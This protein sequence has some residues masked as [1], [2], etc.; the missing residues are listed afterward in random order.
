MTL[1]ILLNRIR[2]D[3]N[4]AFTMTNH[5]LGE[6]QGL[7]NYQPTSGGWTALEILEHVM[8]TNSFLLKFIEK[9]TVKALRKAAATNGLVNWN[10]YLLNRKD[11]WEI[12]IHRS[13]QW[14]RPNHME[15]SR[16][17]SVLEIRLLLDEQKAACLN[18]LEQLRGG[19]GFLHKTTLSVNN[20]GK[21]DVYGYIEFLTQHMI[22]HLMQLDN[23]RKE[24]EMKEC[25]A[26][27]SRS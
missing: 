17:A 24:F 21:L 14:M 12:G 5:W 18:C 15:P 1:Q 3:I 25:D 23:N 8:L 19:E 20:I 10:Q 26:P 27:T 6:S 22:R 7:L 2:F 9:G 16:N 4:N 13:F 11:L